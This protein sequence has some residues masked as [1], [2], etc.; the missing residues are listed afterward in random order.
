EAGPQ[1]EGERRRKRDQ[2]RAGER[3]DVALV[4]RALEARLA[5]RL[6][7]AVERVRVEEAGQG[8]RLEPV[9]LLEQRPEVVLPPQHPV[10]EEVEP[11]GLL[12]LDERREVALDLLV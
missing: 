7:R 1:R 12:R 3:R 2:A 9:G 10:G 6:R 5:G 8:A 11:G 4:Q